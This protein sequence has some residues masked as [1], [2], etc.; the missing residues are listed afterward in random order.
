MEP[1]LAF[2]A[3]FWWIAPAAVGAGGV[4]Y[5]ALTTRSRRAKRLEI[6]A[7]RHE[8][9]LAYRALLSA[10]ADVRFAQAH[11][12]QAQANRATRVAGIPTVADAKRALQQARQAQKNATLAVRSAR[13]RIRAVQAQ[14]HAEG[15][16]QPLPLERLMH[17]H[18]AI[19]ARWLEYETDAAKALAFPQMSDA[20]HP[21]TLAFLRAHS[22]AHRLRPASP[23]ASVSPADFVAYRLAIRAA[24][25][26]LE[27]AEAAARRAAEAGASARSVIWPV[28]RRSVA[29]G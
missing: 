28:P 17:Q 1:L 15:R 29:D 26:T 19:T 2:V 23:K 21:A 12:Q 13:T 20:Q 27:E 10:R 22:E 6:D 9:Q 18:D 8:H 7:A 24:A 3:E 14:R 16:T 5:G 25:H 4:G 11:V